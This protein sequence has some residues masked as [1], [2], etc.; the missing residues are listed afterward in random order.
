MSLYIKERP[1]KALRQH[2]NSSMTD[3]QC[4]SG[5]AKMRRRCSFCSLRS[6]TV[7]VLVEVVRRARESARSGL[8]QPRAYLAPYGRTA[9]VPRR[10]RPVALEYVDSEPVAQLFQ[11]AKNSRG[12]ATFP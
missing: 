5:P 4:E 2:L 1:I 7:C 12:A 9:V 6:A 8:S 3:F 11:R 10:E